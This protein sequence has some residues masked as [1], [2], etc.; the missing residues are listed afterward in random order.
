MQ[1]TSVQIQALDR[2]YKLNLINSIS[3]VKPA[4][5]IGT[6]SESGNENV[7]IFSSVVHIGSNPP[8]LGFI[9]RPQDDVPRDTFTNIKTV[10]FYTI[11]HVVESMIEKA[12]YTSAKLPLGQSEFERMKIESEFI[13][14]FKAPFVKDS[15]T[16][17]GMK[18]VES[19]PMSNGCTFVIGE[20]VMLIAEDESVNDLGQLDLEHTKTAGVSGLNTYY[21]LSKIGSFP[22]VRNNE[23]PDFE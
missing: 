4:N 3:G 7:A 14:G 21:K 19:L 13:D 17:L 12:H 5:V 10:G 18:Y 22:Y 1:L 11:N 20:V 6:I 2:K 8:Q 9:M 15:C 23:I 16:K